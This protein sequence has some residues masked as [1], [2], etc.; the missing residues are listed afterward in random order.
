MFQ[1]Q[2]PKKCQT[3]ESFFHLIR[4]VYAY[5]F[6]LRRSLNLRVTPAIFILDRAPTH[7]I[8]LHEVFGEKRTPQLFLAAD[9][10]LLEVDHLF[11]YFGRSNRSCICNV[12]DQ[13]INLSLKA[14][15]RHKVQ[16]RILNHSFA[17]NEDGIPHYYCVVASEQYNRPFKD[18]C[19]TKSATP[20]DS[21]L[22]RGEALMKH[23]LIT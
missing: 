5:V 20:R 23:L 6:T 8:G 18:A 19:D 2:C 21:A 11:S 13:Y 7:S 4:Q 17:I 1:D 9:D 14:T 10:A 15:I 3:R 16:Q 12:G 22:E